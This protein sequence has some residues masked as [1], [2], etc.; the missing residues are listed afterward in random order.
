MQRR[1]STGYTVVSRNVLRRTCLAAMAER[2]RAAWHGGR[3]RRPVSGLA[4]SSNTQ[5]LERLSSGG[6]NVEDQI[7]FC[8]GSNGIWIAIVNKSLGAVQIS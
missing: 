6:G 1:R 4:T 7:L 5:R 2:K 3:R 8:Y